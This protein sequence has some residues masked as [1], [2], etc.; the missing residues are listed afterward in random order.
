M[1]SLRTIS[2]SRFGLPRER[3][4]AFTWLALLPLL[5]VY[6]LAEADSI[7]FW[8][9]FASVYLLSSAIIGPLVAAVQAR[10]PSRMRAT[11]IAFEM[12][13]ASFVGI[14][15]GSMLVGVAIDWLTA[16]EISQP[17]TWVLLS[18]TVLSGIGV[19]V[20]YLAGNKEQR[21][22]RGYASRD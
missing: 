10:S 17:Y 15:V 20:F 22:A 4:I 16:M 2:N 21:H 13:C 7:L 14:G 11:I 1:L 12:L 19:F 5:I 9:G 18:A 3:F 8:T 6:R